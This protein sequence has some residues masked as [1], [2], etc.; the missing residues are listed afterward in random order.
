M[1]VRA[2]VRTSRT[3]VQE[4][5]EKAEK[6]EIDTVTS[7]IKKRFGDGA[8]MN[9]SE[10]RQPYRIPTGIFMLDMATCGG[11]PFN[12]L[13]MFHGPRSSGKTTAAELCIAGAQQSLPDQVPVLVDVEHTR[14]SAWGA[15]LGVDNERLIYM[16]PDTGENAVDMID[17]MIHARETSLIVVDSIA[18]LVS[19]KEVEE[20]A[21]D[22]ATPGLQAKLVTRMCRKITN[23][24]FTERMRGHFVTLLVLN[25]QRSAIGKWAPHGQEALNLPGGKALE[26]TTMLQVA[27]KNKEN[28]AKSDIGMDVTDFNE[29]SFKIDK[30]K[31]NAGIRS[32]EYQLMRR[33]HDEYELA[34]GQ[35]DDAATML[36][37]AKRIG[38]YSGG[39]RSWTL[40]LPDFK[41][42]F[43]SLN[44]AVIYLYEDRAIYWKLRCFLIADHARRLNLP[45]YFIQYLLG[46]S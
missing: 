24:L 30:C 32:G 31:M 28:M 36:S 19:N 42:T 8:I 17:A 12:Q 39:G 20:S 5:K 13:T 41:Q 15:K 44:E 34:E 26:F 27:F 9:A 38:A 11:I 21:E 35:I 40:E 45:D 6:R 23:G 33:D 4:K 18:A 29:H 2:P 7:E 46:H 3:I 1:P 14:D 43:G 22:N 10:Q 25:Q 37:Y 16:N